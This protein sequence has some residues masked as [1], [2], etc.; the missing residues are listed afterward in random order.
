MKRFVT[1]TLALP[2]LLTAYFSHAQVVNGYARVTS[3]SGATLA[4]SSVDESAD[5]FE[6]DEWVIIMQMQDDVIGTTTNTAGFGNLGSINS[7]GLYEVRQIDSHVESAGSPTSITL[8]NAPTN[9]YNTCTNCSVQIITFRQFGSPDYTTTGNMSAF[10]WDGDI[11]GV[12]AIYVAGVLTLGHN[13]D[14]D[15]DG[16]RGAGANGGSST[17]CSGSSNYR[18]ATTGNHADKGEGIYRATDLNYAAGRAHILNGAGGGNSHNGGGG[19]GEGN[20][21]FATRGANGGGIILLK[22]TE[23][24]TTTCAGI[25][26]SANGGS[27]LTTSG[28]DGAGGGGAG[29]SI[30]FE[31]ATWSVSGGCPLTVSSNGGDGGSVNSG[32]THG[33]GG[34][35]G[36]GVVFY[37]DA[38]PTTN[39]TS[40]T[41][42]GDG[43]CN[44]SSMPC[45]SIAGNGGGLDDEGVF[46]MMTGPLPVELVDFTAYPINEDAVQIVWKTLSE[47]N[48]DYF[49][50]LRSGDG[51][52][53]DIV[54]RTEG[55]GNSS[56]EIEYEIMDYNPLNG[57]SYYKLKQ[58][59]FDGQY[60]FS[61]TVSVLRNSEVLIYPNP[62]NETIYV[63]LTDIKEGQFI[64]SDLLGRP[65]LS[66]LISEDENLIEINVSD[67]PNGVY[68]LSIDKENYRF[69]VAH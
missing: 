1:L 55:A 66:Q 44:N 41:L 11:G 24:V 39:V 17:G 29:G 2:L 42:N 59:D 49:D 20:N 6:D 13:L 26:I 36:Q 62:A 14:A 61:N 27:I 21:G 65:I 32:A 9:A 50:V 69:I 57:A 18:V 33:G 56:S 8:K 53:W 58:V 52:H 23:I 48:N 46:D 28:N 19:G 15:Q 38:E 22:A 3:I 4:V 10:P 64:V 30:V 67:F 45:S 51:E 60:D 47:R 12:L 25:S 31:V 54:A 43:G 40:E 7:A 5:S 68:N 63:H 35:G 34:G 16:F 37:S